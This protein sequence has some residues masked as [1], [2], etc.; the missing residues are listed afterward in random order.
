MREAV[1]YWLTPA[2]T[3][4]LGTLVGDHLEELARRG[5]SGRLRS[6]VLITGSG[7]ARRLPFPPP[8]GANAAARQR[9][10]NAQANA[11]LGQLRAS[12]WLVYTDAA[13]WRPGPA[14]YR[15]H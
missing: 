9:W 11:M 13:G 1:G 3:R 4:Q 12:G 7:L 8:D 15:A 14:W 5:V 10:R 6:G 2:R